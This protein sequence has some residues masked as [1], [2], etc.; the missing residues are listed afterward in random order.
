M[1]APLQLLLFAL[2]VAASGCTGNTVVRSVRLP[3][4]YM[5]EFRVCFPSTAFERKELRYEFVAPGESIHG[6]DLWTP[7]GTVEKVNV[8]RASNLVFESG[9]HYFLVRTKNQPIL[10]WEIGVSVLHTETDWSQWLDPT[11]QYL[12]KDASYDLVIGA[13]PNQARPLA[14]GPMMRYRLKRYQFGHTS[15]DD[16]PPLPCPKPKYAR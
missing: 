12:P 2:S 6:G 13:T 8:L 16:P 7:E 4:E 1:R 15:E 14:Y 11:S 9:V 5:V 3:H 10:S